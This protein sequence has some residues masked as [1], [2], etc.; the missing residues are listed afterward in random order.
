MAD[1]I[2]E[3]MLSIVNSLIGDPSSIKQ[4][5]HIARNLV[6]EYAPYLPCEI[7]SV[8]NCLNAYSQKTGDTHEDENELILRALNHY[9]H[10]TT[11]SAKN[12][13]T[14]D[15]L[16]KNNAPFISNV[17][18]TLVLRDELVARGFFV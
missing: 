11:I 7:F 4:Y 8:K 17:K 14:S 16:H 9:L 6:D 2:L 5:D 3:E 18:C 15:F 13:D 10:M 12:I 1:N